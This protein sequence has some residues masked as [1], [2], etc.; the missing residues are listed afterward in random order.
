MNDHRADEYLDG[1]LTDEQQA[2]FLDHLADCPVCQDDLHG[3]V[4]LRDREATLRAQSGAAA[5]PVSL[6]AVRA[7]RR[8]RTI[9]LVAAGVAAAAAVALVVVR[10]WRPASSTGPALTL[11]ATR[12][13]EPRLSWGPAAAYRPYDPMRSSATPGEYIAP[14]VIAELARRDDCPGL[15]AT[16]VLSGELVRAQQQFQR[17]ASTPAVDADRAGLAILQHD[18]AAALELADR[19][20]RAAP[21]HPVALWNRAL[22]LRDL[23]LG[24]AAAEAFDRCAEVDPAWAAEARRRAADARGPLLNLRD[25]YQQAVDAGTAMVAGGPPI[26]IDLALRFPVRAAIRLDD[27]IALAD[28]AAR[29]GELRPLATELDRAT[30]SG[31]LARLDA[32]APRR[33]PPSLT[34]PYVAWATTS[35]RPDDAA[36]RAWLAEAVAA[37][38]DALILGAGLVTGRID[39]VP[40]AIAS[41]ARASPWFGTVIELQAIRGLAGRGADDAVE[42]RL[43][44]LEAACAAGTLPAYPCLRISYQRAELSFTRYL[45][46]ATIA[47]GTEALRLAAHTGEWGVRWRALKL[48]ATAERLRSRRAS[49]AAY[50]EEYVASDQSCMAQREVGTVLGVFAFERGDLDSA[51]TH[52]RARPGCD[53]A[54]T[55]VELA[56]EADLARAGRSLRAPE[57]LDHDFLAL[58]AADPAVANAVEYYRA[59]AELGVRPDAIERLR[60][61]RTVDD[62]VAL[63]A[64]HPAVAEF[65]AATL[66]VDAARR[67]HWSDAAAVL[68]DGVATCALAIGSD[69]PAV[70]VV[71]VGGDGQARG[72]AFDA[73]PAEAAPIPGPLVDSV[74]GCAVVDVFATAPWSGRSLGLPPSLPWRFVIG[75]RDAAA[76][77]ATAQ[78][79]VVRDPRPP[80]RLGLSPLAARVA[81]APGTIVLA[82]P[83]A[84]VPAVAAA[85]A[86]ATVLEIHAHTAPSPG[87]DVPALALSDS[88]AGWAATAEAIRGWRLTAA[89]VVL[90]ADCDAASAA[91]YDQVVWGLPSAFIAA[92]ARAVVAPLGPV[93][94]G[95][96]AEVFSRIGDAVAR[97]HAVVDAVAEI[98]AEKIAQDRA[99]W[100]KN[101]VVYQ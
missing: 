61:L 1:L 94:D 47:A 89:P 74:A 90:L 78:R 58:R 35:A 68:A 72:V 10:P 56:L 42:A 37:N 25:G 88:P 23:G 101:V 79:V 54:P 67:G 83:Q 98:R 66:F 51:I 39:D 49:S 7:R 3:G 40:P 45:A 33:L 84:T 31:V 99:S 91:R 65:A 14:A 63:A 81:E 60:R 11:A 95:E 9:A 24:L 4:Q 93:P 12:P 73:A 57:A 96:T 13:I 19:A 86:S 38:A 70:A 17:C 28:T 53:A 41:A 8:L 26:P 62:E 46:P 2:T 44:A 85:A 59:R 43:V 30:G 21:D 97:G 64:S 22:A 5:A 55:M 92:G 16:Y 48:I 82:G 18:P 80:T 15:A 6:A 50:Y 27:A 71:A 69:G 100:V 20:L 32:A 87:S 29:L 76:A 34:G 36:W 52:L 75:R 77:A